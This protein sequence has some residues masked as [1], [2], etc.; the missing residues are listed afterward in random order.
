MILWL[1]VDAC[2]PWQHLQVTEG[3]PF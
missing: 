1:P 2:V 3:H